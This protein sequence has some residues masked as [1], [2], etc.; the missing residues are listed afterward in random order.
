LQNCV[1]DWL[2]FSKESEQLKIELNQ[3][4]A[5]FKLINIRIQNNG[6]TPVET[7]RVD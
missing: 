7:L 2:T 4:E 1:T 5:E 6:Q 3:I